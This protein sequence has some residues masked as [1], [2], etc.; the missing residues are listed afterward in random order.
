MVFLILW[1]SFDLSPNQF[2]AEVLSS[3]IEEI[4]EKNLAHFYRSTPPLAML[5]SL[6]VGLDSGYIWFRS[7][8]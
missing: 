6:L 7:C 4:S 3:Q 8:T 5:D 1:S 2:V